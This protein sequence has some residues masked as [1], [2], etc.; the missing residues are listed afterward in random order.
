MTREAC[1]QRTV[2]N[3]CTATSVT[4][5]FTPL[6]HWCSTD[7]PEQS[8]L[9]QHLQLNF[10]PGCW[11]HSYLTRC[12]LCT[13]VILASSESFGGRSTHLW[14]K[15]TI[16]LSSFTTTHNK[17]GS[18]L[19][20]SHAKESFMEGT[21]VFCSLKDTSPLLGI[22]ANWGCR[23]HPAAQRSHSLSFTKLLDEEHLAKTHIRQIDCQDK[24]PVLKNIN[25]LDFINFFQLTLMLF[26]MLCLLILTKNI[27]CNLAFDLLL[28]SCYCF[29]KCFQS[30][31]AFLHCFLTDMPSMLL[32]IML[33]RKV[34]C[35]GKILSC[36]MS[37]IQLHRLRVS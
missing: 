13:A 31:F 3:V 20:K 29:L 35:L 24:I 23:P 17:W 5:V 11:G 12:C 37:E 33:W 6:S 18:R 32:S 7:R 28:S 21:K 15:V 8:I 25:I 30:C 14:R 10:L 19:W 34:L 27:D 22:A 4:P 9:L 1:W 16:S 2:A 26:L 36:T